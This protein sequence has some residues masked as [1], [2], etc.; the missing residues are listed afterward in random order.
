VLEEGE[1]EGV[2]EEVVWPTRDLPEMTDADKKF[3]S[4]QR[5]V[6]M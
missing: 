5:N 6:G 4:R 1:G 2:K 3:S